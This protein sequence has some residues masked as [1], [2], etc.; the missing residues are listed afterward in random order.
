MD[1][2]FTIIVA[3]FLYLL[4]GLFIWQLW[5]ILVVENYSYDPKFDKLFSISILVFLFLWPFSF[6][7]ILKILYF[8]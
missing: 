6:F 1:L 8:D 3:I 5:T 2:F 4:V 7:I